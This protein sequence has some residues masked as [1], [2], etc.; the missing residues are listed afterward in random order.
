MA[1]IPDDA[2]I[3]EVDWFSF[4]GPC[5][6][7]SVLFQEPTLIRLFDG[8]EA[9]GRRLEIAPDCPLGIE[10][11]HGRLRRFALRG[12]GLPTLGATG[13]AVQ[14]FGLFARS[15]GGASL[16]PAP[17]SL[18]LASLGTSGEDGVAIDLGTADSFYLDLAPIELSG[19]VPAGAF[20]RAQAR[21]SVGG[22]PDQ[23]LGALTIT[24]TDQ[25]G[26]AYTVE[27][28]FTDIA[29]P[30]HTV[31]V[32]DNHR[33]VA[34]V[35]GHTGTAALV[36]AWPRRLGKLDGELECYVGGFPDHTLIDIDGIPYRGN[37]LR[38]LAET[39]GPAIDYKSEFRLQAAGIPEL[40]LT[41]AATGRADN[42][43][44]GPT[45]LCLNDGRFAIDV[46][47]FVPQGDR[48]VGRAVPLTADTGYFWFFDRDNVEVVVKVLDGCPVNDRFW[49]FAAGLTNVEVL[50]TVTDT[51]SGIAETYLNP[52]GTAF[53][54]IQSTGAFATCR[55]GRFAATALTAAT[56]NLSPQRTTAE[57]EDLLRRSQPA[58]AAAQTTAGGSTLKLN[59]GRFRVEGR[60][61]TPQGTSGDGHGE[62]LTDDSGTFWFFDPDNIETV[63]KVL[64]ACSVNGRFWVF[65]AGLT[66][67]E[68]EITVTDTETGAMKTY[69]NP[70]G[71]AFKPIQDTGAFSA[72][73]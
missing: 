2:C 43:T 54:P 57:L 46:E 40:T 69:L 10:P 34:E 36:S 62:P 32:L 24:K 27:P 73:P 9:M 41:R 71:T 64:D 72:C 38:V 12:T 70:Q 22:V 67:V 16:L 52:Q 65:A 37:E 49:L 39:E 14:A 18:T 19:D 56:A 5:R 35:E 4:V 31:Q 30:T 63:I 48:G 44:P 53:L 11:E 13:A 51:R 3:Q 59:E 25:A 28:D 23:P 55:A 45:R 15:L 33:L 8:T 60:W 1:F 58:A 17:G 68:V 29:S 7:F 6:G 61:R 26:T 20:L 66:N 50:V 21:G 47:W 42:C